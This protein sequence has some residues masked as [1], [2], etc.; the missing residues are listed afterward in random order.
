V[1]EY[2]CREEEVGGEKGG[3]SPW[4][5]KLETG[6]VHGSGEK[7]KKKVKRRWVGVCANSAGKKCWDSLSL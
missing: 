2:T 5:P 3:G 4:S 7:K 6:G 1:L